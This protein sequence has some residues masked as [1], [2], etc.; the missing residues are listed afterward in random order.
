MRHVFVLIGMTG[1]SL[2]LAAEA[3]DRTVPFAGR[4]S[5]NQ[6]SMPLTD[7]G[8]AMAM[9]QRSGVPASDVPVGHMQMLRTITLPASNAPLRTP[10]QTAHPLSTSQVTPLGFRRAD[11]AWSHTPQFDGRTGLSRSAHDASAGISTRVIK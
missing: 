7:V 2:S 3:A 1:L 4:P 11:F 8:T 10:L 5:P 9:V 6:V